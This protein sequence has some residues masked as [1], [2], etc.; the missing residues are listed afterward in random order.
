MITEK[1][2]FGFWM[3]RTDKTNLIT[4]HSAKLLKAVNGLMEE[5]EKQGVKFPVNPVTR[6]QVS[7]AEYGG[8]RP[9]AC[10]IGAPGSAHK[11]GSA[12]DIFDP[13]NLIDVWCVDQS[14]KGELLERYGI[15]IEH[16]ASTPKW[17]HWS[18]RRPQSGNRVFIP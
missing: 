1:Q 17:S 10:P 18:I 3:Y 15:Y 2:Y 7:G 6:S 9:L 13:E 16:P 11:Q 8:F 12:I 5:A 4:E 14:E